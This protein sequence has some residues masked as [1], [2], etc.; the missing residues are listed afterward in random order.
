MDTTYMDTFMDPASV[1]VIGV[2]RNT[3]EG[4]FNVI[5]N[6]LDFGFK[7][8]IYPVNPLAEDIMG[9]KTYKDVRDIGKDID[10]AIIATPRETVPRIAR[11]CAELG[12]KGA[13]VVPQGFA[14]ADAEGKDLQD[15]LTQIARENGIRIL[16]PNTLGIVNAFSGF[17]SSFMPLLREKVP[18]G[19]ICQSGIF[20]VGSSI[21]TGMMGKGIDIANGCDVDFA[22]ALDY[23]GRDDDI[24]VI[25][26]HVEGMKQGREFF[27]VAREVALKKPII[28]LK[29]AR[30]DRGAQAAQS[31]SGAMVGKHEVFEAAF[32][33]AGIISARN[34][35]EVM[36][37]TKAFLHLPLM[38]GNR[39]GMVTFSGAGGI[40]LIDTLEENGLEMAQ[41]SPE[42]IKT[43]KNLSP[44]WMPI[45]NPLDI[46]PALMKHGMAHVYE[47]ALKGLLKD[48]AV[49]AAIC[50]A[51]APASQYSHL[52]ITDVIKK[53]AASFNEKP[54][55]AWLYG[56]N[57][58][59]VSRSLEEGGHVVSFPSLPRAARTLATLY[60]RAQFL[61]QSRNQSK[62]HPPSD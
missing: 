28:A 14:D 5:E 62:T 2:S 6:M 11:D 21:F 26:I 56:P 53:T 17:T 61:S 25:F 57:Q 27:E 44:D 31:H 3:G 45:D 49:D 12:I 30:T 35:D 22:D 15:Q 16:G 41:L 37:F 8:E 24:R 1:A 18:I 29:T 60:K 55:A 33:Q 51:I 23:F 43:I 7:G 54:V 13:I 32:R 19:V 47:I 10:V 50:I 40:I 42:T 4:S 34:P 59:R 20:F 39:V 9:L 52:D 58:P 48:P 38:Q 46:W 36:D